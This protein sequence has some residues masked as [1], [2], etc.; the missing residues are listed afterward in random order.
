MKKYYLAYGSNLNR[1]QM[2]NRCPG[3]KPLGTAVIE[4][5]RLLF[6]GSKSGSYLTIEPEEGSYVPVAVWAVTAPD[7]QRL[8]FYEGY[9]TFYYKKDMMVTYKGILSG[10][11][12]TVNAF[13][14]I[15]H[16]DRPLGIPSQYYLATCAEG[17]E[18]FGFDISPL[19]EAYEFSCEET[20][21]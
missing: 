6:K 17:Y 16:E 8:D 10:T 2:M 1:R 9:P 21:R 7:E 5:Y 12:R 14:Y 15:M 19:A 18:D 13:V 20:Y 11:I 4:N 3:A